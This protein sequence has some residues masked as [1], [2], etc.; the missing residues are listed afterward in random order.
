M[1]PC[2]VSALEMKDQ[3]KAKCW[4]VT[5]T[6]VSIGN[7]HQC[8][9]E[10]NSHLIIK[11]PIG[12]ELAE[13]MPSPRTIKTHLPAQLLPP[14]FWEQN[15]KV[16]LKRPT[17]LHRQRK[18]HKP[19]QN[20]FSRISGKSKGLQKYFPFS[21]QSPWESKVTTKLP[22]LDFRKWHLQSKTS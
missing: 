3:C 13:A 22:E 18:W 6:C 15:C 2:Y 14:S 5:I 10:N 7:K 20:M 4:K 17:L 16:R 21:V 11:H 1:L 12:L 8:N 9:L 19:G